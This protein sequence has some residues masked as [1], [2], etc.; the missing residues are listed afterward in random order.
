VG[1]RASTVRAFALSLPEATEIETWETAT[2][3]VRNKIFCTFSDEERRLWIKSIE[4]EQRALIDQDPDAYFRPPYVGPKGWV[5]AVLAKADGG[6]VRELI[7]E[8]W[9]MTAPKRLARTF[10]EAGSG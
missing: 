1:I 8:A 10:D 5:G 7:T 2:F 3:R 6:E 4:E 9:C